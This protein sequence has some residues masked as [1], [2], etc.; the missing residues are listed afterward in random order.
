MRKWNESNEGGRGEGGGQS[1]KGMEELMWNEK[2]EN[3]KKQKEVKKELVCVEK[4][5]KEALF[6]LQAGQI[7]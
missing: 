7:F 3:E 4:K 6:Q 2:K 5:V 1:I